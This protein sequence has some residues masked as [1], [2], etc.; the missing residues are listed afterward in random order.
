MSGC[1]LL[2]GYHSAQHSHV[3]SGQ[4]VLQWER[5]GLESEPLTAR[6][7][8]LFLRTFLLS[9]YL[10]DCIIRTKALPSKRYYWKGLWGNKH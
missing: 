10:A 5:L 8:R 3:V 1:Y 6:L 2:E 9:S 7:M 4:T